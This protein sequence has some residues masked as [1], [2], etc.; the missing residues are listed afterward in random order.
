MGKTEKVDGKTQY[1]VAEIYGRLRSQAFSLQVHS[2]SS[3]LKDSAIVAVLMETGYDGAVATLA[4]VSDGTVSFYFSNGGGRIGLGEHEAVRKA[5]V[6]Y[7][8]FAQQFLSMAKP[9]TA[10]P[11]PTLGD[12]TFYF[13][14]RE[15]V[16]CFSAKEDDL[17]K[18]RS[19]FSPL[20]FKAHQ[21]ITEARLVEQRREQNFDE[22]RE[23]ATS[24]D[25]RRLGRLLEALPSPD[26][27]DSSGLTPLMAAAY[28]GQPGCV[29]VLLAARAVVDKKDAEGYTALMFACNGGSLPCVRLLAE[30]GANVNEMDKDNSTPIMFAAQHGHNDIVRYLLGR[31]ADPTFVGKHGLSAIGFAQ[32]NGLAE[33]ERILGGK[34]G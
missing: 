15:G 20:F 11:L 28:S 3:L 4:T 21:V 23:A 34:S 6:E 13:I 16:R 33:T 1:E 25:E 26:V 7:L 29:Q 5:A 32:Q 9:T 17:G 8:T 18:K 2:V 12:T 19:P 24:G 22:L 10:F 14:T 27:S 30:N 31:G